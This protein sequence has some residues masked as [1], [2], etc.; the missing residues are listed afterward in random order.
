MGDTNGS[1]EE[2][3]KAEGG[4]KS[5]LFKHGCEVELANPFHLLQ[6]ESSV[7]GVPN[8]S[9]FQENTDTI[10]TYKPNITNTNKRR[11]VIRF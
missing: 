8:E 9:E 11:P 2:W 4:N 7:L 10:K 1:R 6:V 3:K 5:K